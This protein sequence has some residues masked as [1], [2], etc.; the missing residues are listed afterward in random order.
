M[1][2]IRETNTEERQKHGKRKGGMHSDCPV[3][4]IFFYV[5]KGSGSLLDLAIQPNQVPADPVELNNCFN[6]EVRAVVQF[7]EI[8]NRFQ[9]R[10]NRQGDLLISYAKTGEGLAIAIIRRSE[11]P[12][13]ETLSL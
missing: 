9:V 1:G 11:N 3:K 7:A 13:L 2:F 8:Q 12:V 5:R 10:Q 4:I 6:R